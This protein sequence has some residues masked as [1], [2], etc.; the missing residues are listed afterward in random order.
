MKSFGSASSTGSDQEHDVGGAS[1]TVDV[2]YFGEPHAQPRSRTGL[3][4]QLSGPMPI[5]GDDAIRVASP[6]PD[7]LDPSSFSST[8]VLANKYETG[9]KTLPRG[10]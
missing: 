1:N 2:T 10:R 3:L 5:I 4:H 6:Q 7:G 8:D 9:E